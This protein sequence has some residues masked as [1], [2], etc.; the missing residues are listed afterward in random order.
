MHFFVQKC[1]HFQTKRKGNSFYCKNTP[2]HRDAF[3]KFPFCWIYYCH[4][5]KSTGKE[6]GKTHL[7]ALSCQASIVVQAILVKI[8][9]A[10]ADECSTLA[11]PLFFSSL[12][13]YYKYIYQHTL[14]FNDLLDLLD[15]PNVFQNSRELFLCLP[16]N[17]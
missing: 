7:C 8:S 12:S 15:L 14:Y 10:A 5:S 6:T 16:S 3:C 4:S 13:P 1:K 2:L 9:L 11:R 17:L